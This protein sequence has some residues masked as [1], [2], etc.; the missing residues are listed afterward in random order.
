MFYH[1]IIIKL[2]FI[3]IMI[4]FIMIIIFYHKILLAKA[5]HSI[6]LFHFIISFN[7][8]ILLGLVVKLGFP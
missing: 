8:L 7:K 2:Y 5:T 6:L 3:F 4:I 1:K